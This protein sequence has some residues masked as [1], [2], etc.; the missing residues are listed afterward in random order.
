MNTERHLDLEGEV[1]NPNWK[2][3]WSGKIVWRGS[4]D[5]SNLAVGVAK[6][7]SPTG[8]KTQPTWSM[9]YPEPPSPAVGS[10]TCSSI[11]SAVMPL[12]LS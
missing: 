8:D 9:D 10:T 5:D 11:G 12:A 2:R 1:D 4:P 6:G 7:S 3:Q